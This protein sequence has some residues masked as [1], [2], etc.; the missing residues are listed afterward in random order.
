MA[1]RGDQLLQPQ[2][3]H[4]SPQR[5]PLDPDGRRQAHK[6]RR[7]LQNDVCRKGGRIS[8]VSRREYAALSDRRLRVR[9]LDRVAQPLVGRQDRGVSAGEWAIAIAAPR[10]RR[11][12]RQRRRRRR[13][14]RLQ[15]KGSGL[16]V[17]ITRLYR[18][19]DLLPDSVSILE[20]ERREAGLAENSHDLRIR[21]LFPSEAHSSQSVALLKCV[22]SPTL[23]HADRRL[24]FAEANA[25]SFICPSKAHSPMASYRAAPTLFSS[26]QI[27]ARRRAV[28]PL[29]I[30]R[31]ASAT[32][33]RSVAVDSPAHAPRSPRPLPDHVPAAQSELHQRRF[34]PRP[35][36]LSSRQPVQRCRRLG[37]RVCEVPPRDVDPR[38]SAHKR[39]RECRLQGRQRQARRSRLRK[40]RPTA[41]ASSSSSRRPLQLNR[42][43]YVSQTAMTQLV[44][45]DKFFL[46]HSQFLTTE[47]T[48]K[49][50]E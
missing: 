20:S 26:A 43:G 45:D 18:R 4:L 24:S 38:I 10:R 42:C 30:R 22:F 2:S 46:E 34:G 25:P 27:T 49:F 35:A 40:W 7:R 6:K 8:G 23:P 21:E 33:T 1:S 12:R 5:Q 39:D 13:R 14:R 37:Q 47:D 17:K 48:K 16:V 41:F 32:N 11:R 3:D 36:H 31:Y 9:R 19:D 29:V 15:R 44:A 28:L 50:S